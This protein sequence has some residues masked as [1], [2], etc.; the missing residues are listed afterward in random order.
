MAL[1]HRMPAIGEASLDDI[2]VT[3]SILR[4]GIRSAARRTWDLQALAR[5]RRLPAAAR[6]RAVR[7][8]HPPTERHRRPPRRP[9][10]EQHHPGRADPLRADARPGGRVAARD[11]PRRHRDAKRGREAPRQGGQDPFRRGPR[12]VRPLRV[13]VREEDREHDSRAAQGD[14]QL[15]RLVTP[16]LHAG[17][18]I[19]GR[20]AR[21]VRAPVGRGA[22][23]SG[24]SR[25]PLVPALPDC[26]VG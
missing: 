3:A 19:L 13:G 24:P 22:D 15:V 1:S 9:R 16:A 14:R 21:S 10:P 17:R 26:P 11:R 5:G 12:G 20:R 23:L 6:W 4:N 25:D 2:L 18:E 7:H 8:R